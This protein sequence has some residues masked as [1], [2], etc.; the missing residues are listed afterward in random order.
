MW[1][2]PKIRGIML[3]VPISRTIAFWGLCTVHVQAEAKRH[4][5]RLANTN[6]TISVEFVLQH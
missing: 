4:F 5:A 1:G 3:R 2:F 6:R